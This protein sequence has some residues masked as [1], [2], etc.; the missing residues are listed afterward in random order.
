MNIFNKAALEGMKKNR[1][2]TLVTIVGVILSSAM[3]TAVATFGTSLLSYMTNASIAKYGGW[4]VEFANADS[5]FVKARTSDREVKDTAV[6]ANLGYA[7]LEG[8]KSPEK[9]YLF[10]SGFNDKT[11]ETLPITL[12]SGRLPE[13]SGEVLVPSH[14]AVKAGVGISTGDVLT[15]EVGERM[16]QG[17]ILSQHDVYQAGREHL[18]NTAEETYTVVG[19]CERPGFEEHAAPGYTLITKS[20]TEGR[21]DSFSLFVTL[22]NPRNVRNYMSGMD[23]TKEYVL[24]DDV[25]RFMGASD[26]KLFNTL[27]YT[28]SSILTAIVMLGSIF[29]IYNSFNI[30]LNERTHQFG[31]LMSVGATARQL[32]NSVLFEGLCVG[33]AGVPA[34]ILAG[35]G[36]IGLILPVVADNFSTIIN[37]TVP[38]SLAVSVPALIAA[39][40]VSLVTVLISAY[41]PARK[42]AATPVMDCIRQ[43]GEIKIQSGAVKTS[44]LVQRIWG[45]EGTLALRNFKRNKRRCRSVVLSLTLSVVLLVSGSAFGTTLKRLAK[46]YTVE[47]DGDISFY[48]HEM[49]EEEM[50]SLYGRLKNA[51][52]VYRSTYQSN[53]TCRCATGDFPEDF[54]EDYRRAMGEGTS[55]EQSLGE[56][57]EFPLDIQFIEDSVYYDFIKSLGLDEAQY[58]GLEAKVLI[59]GADTTDHTTCFANST[60]NFTLISDSGEQEKM[61]E[62]T[63]VD[64]YPLD[65]LP[66]DSS[67]PMPAYH[68]MAVIPWQMKPQFELPG[69][70]QTYGMTF[71]SERPSQSMAQMQ[72]M[73]DEQ[74]ISSGYVL[75]NLSSAVDLFRSATFVV[76]V[77]TYVFVTM[78][79]LIAVANVFNTISTNIRLR[80]RELAMLR[81]V[82]MSDRDFNKMMYFECA[83]YGMRTLMWGIPISGLISWLIYKGMTTVERLDDFAFAFP[84]GTMAVSVLGVFLVV[85]ITIVYA[86]GKIRKENIMDA[87][88]D[89]MT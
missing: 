52:R 41:I 17:E 27:L 34:G 85:F 49:G 28:V 15:L 35:V 5:S 10:I 73:I 2:R 44:G 69:Q 62:A 26:N 74:G 77:F 38:L 56:Q 82:G 75:L 30:S 6:S 4:H 76:D 53:Q 84:W 71:W 86:A 20:D 36:G 63:F 23:G 14:I 70:P 83:F 42:A 72:S 88:R 57:L 37:S 25:L 59:V 67:A 65:P 11:F 7:M 22:K 45:V 89:D 68:F 33:M 21:E 79:S 58:S 31:I 64:S 13:N 54:S 12:I 50:F 16:S 24:N 78:I 3:I 29:L 80:R 81:S 60:M 8:G 39:A 1:T 61:M 47:M 40:A 55:G 46:E 19:I 51:G 48:T 43:T 32:R 66:R 87:L 9:P 18:V